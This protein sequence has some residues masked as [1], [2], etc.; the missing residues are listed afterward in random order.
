MKLNVI[1]PPAPNTIAKYLPEIRKPTTEKQLQAWLTFFKNHA[2]ETWGMT[3][4]LFLDQQK[5]KI[6]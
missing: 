6:F 1:D 2:F 3:M 4:I 5:F